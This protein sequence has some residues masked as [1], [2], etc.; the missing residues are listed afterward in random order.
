MGDHVQV[1]GGANLERE[2]AAA[3]SCMIVKHK[4]LT[5]FAATERFSSYS[6]SSTAD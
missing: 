6:T 3:R 5:F 4:C 1:H 2:I